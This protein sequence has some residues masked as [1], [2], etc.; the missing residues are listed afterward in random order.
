MR[1]VANN[2]HSTNA[3][4]Y[5]PHRHCELHIGVL[6]EPNDGVPRM[7]IR[8][9]WHALASVLGI[10]VTFVIGDRRLDPHEAL[11]LQSEISTFRDILQIDS[12]E[13]SYYNL[14]E[15]T[16]AWFTWAG[17]H[18]NC[19]FIMKLDKDTYP[20]LLPILHQ[21]VQLPRNST[22]PYYIG[23][24]YGSFTSQKR[25]ATVVQDVN[26]PWYMHDQFP[27]SAYPPYMSG[28][29]YIVSRELAH[30]IGLYAPSTLPYRLED[31][32]IGLLLARMRAHVNYV[33]NEAWNTEV[34]S[35]DTAY[36]NPSYS[37]AFNMYGR[38]TADMAGAGN[39]G[40]YY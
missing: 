23:S 14:F 37:Q 33:T 24:M 25:N 17:Q 26:S 30:L 32:G 7:V 12:L 15:K 11:L 40:C 20:R 9:T 8:R 31:A 13:D 16:L 10:Q 34:C 4:D 28:G 18:S 38:Y 36:D 6:T 19:S 27:H 5:V 39:V 1:Y 22:S 3:S 29:A 35:L 2:V 21:L